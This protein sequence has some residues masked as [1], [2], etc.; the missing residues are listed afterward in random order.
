MKI[1]PN[2]DLKAT[3]TWVALV[4]LAGAVV[5]GVVLGVSA[6]FVMAP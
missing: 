1:V 6:L 2:I 4:A 3:N 5:L